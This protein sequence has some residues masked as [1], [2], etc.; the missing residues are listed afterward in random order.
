MCTKHSIEQELRRFSMATMHE[1]D[2][3]VNSHC[4]KHWVMDRAIAAHLVAEV[5]PGLSNVKELCEEDARHCQHG[6][7]T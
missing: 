4:H 2:T 5:P 7:P 3:A 1:P 6:P